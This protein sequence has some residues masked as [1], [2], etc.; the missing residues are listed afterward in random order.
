VKFLKTILNSFLSHDATVLDEDERVE[1]LIKSEEI[2]Y[3][4]IELK[5]FS[6][7]KKIKELAL[8]KE[9]PFKS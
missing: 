1:E 3:E 5:D 6:V 8:K 7:L 9:P 2:E 4:E